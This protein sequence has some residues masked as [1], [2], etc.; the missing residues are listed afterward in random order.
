MTNYRH[1]FSHSAI[2]VLNSGLYNDAVLLILAL[3]ISSIEIDADS[4]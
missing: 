3:L 2:E 1:N 4:L